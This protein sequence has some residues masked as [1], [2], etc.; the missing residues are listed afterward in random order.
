VSKILAPADLEGLVTAGLIRAASALGH[1][2][3][4]ARSDPDTCA[5][6]YE[7]ADCGLDATQTWGGTRGQALAVACESAADPA[8]AARAG[9]WSLSWT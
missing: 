5:E 9:T 3:T 7:C 1:R 8:A 4:F 6:T 2:M